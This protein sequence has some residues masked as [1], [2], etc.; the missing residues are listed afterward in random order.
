MRAAAFRLRP[1]SDLRAE[2][3]RLIEAE[4][5]RAGCILTCVGSL[6]RAR[7]RAP[8]SAGEAE[9]VRTY[10]EPMEIVSATGTLGVGGLHV[11]VSLARRDGSCVG[12]HLLEGCIVHTTAELVIGEL[13]GVEFRREP[14]AATGY[15]EL[16]VAPRAAEGEPPA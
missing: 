12:G 16:V 3:R 13:E 15:R 14:D 2:L 11:H 5:L 1:G 8:G 6:S 10:D 7:L 4:G 9:L